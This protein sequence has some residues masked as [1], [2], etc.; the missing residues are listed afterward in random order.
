MSNAELKESYPKMQTDDHN[1][2][3]KLFLTVGWVT[4]WWIVIYFGIVILFAFLY[5]RYATP[6]FE[7]Q[8]DVQY[9]DRSKDNSIDLG[10]LVSSP[11]ADRLNEEMTLLNSKG[12]KMR[13][14]RSLPLQASYYLTEHVKS[15]EIY[16]ASPFKVDVEIIDSAIIGSKIDFEIIDQTNY[17]IHYN[18]QGE[19]ISFKYNFDKDYNTP[20]FN[21]KATLNSSDP[22][23]VNNKYYFVIND[24]EVI[25]EKIE[26]EI[27]VEVDNLYGG[28]ITIYY[29]DKN[30][31]K[32]KDVV[33]T[34]AKEIVNLSL[35]RKANGAKT[36]I[37]FIQG[38]IDSLEKELFNQETLLKDFKKE[39]LII[40]PE[41]AENNVV[42]KLNTIDQ[43]K[44][45][46][47][48]EE[49]SL[50]WLKDF[51]ENKNNDIAAL[52][53]Y[54]GDFKFNDF[55]PYLNSLLSLEKEKENIG[56]SVPKTD[57]RLASINKQI[58]QVKINFK[59][60][61]KNAEEKLNVRKKYLTEEQK[62]YETEFLGLPEIQSEFARLT[63]LN[64]L[65][66]KYYLLLLEK[67][68]EYEI[69]LAG[70]SSDYVILDAGKQG[71]L[72]SPVSTKVWGIC[73]LIGI[74]VSFAHVYLKFISH[75]TIIGVPDVESATQVPLLGVLPL[76]TTSKTELAQIVV[77]KNPKSHIAEA[78]RTIRSNIQYFLRNDKTT[79]Q[80]I[81]ITSTISGEGKTFIA[82]NLANVIAATGKKVVL[83]DFDLRKPKIHKAIEI[84]NDRGVSN[85]LI[86][87]FTPEECIKYS[88]EC[89]CDILIAGPVPPN[90]A[91]LL[92]GHETELLLEYLQLHYDY[93]I[94]DCPP[95]GI[96]SDSLP[97]MSRVDLSIY[98]LRANYSKLTFIENINRL[99]HN[100]RLTNLCMIVNDANASGTDYGY[101]YGYGY[102]ESEYHDYYSDTGFFLPLW[103]K[104]FKTN[105]KNPN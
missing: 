33:N 95:V 75:N 25:T 23:N 37:T 93:I 52:A 35:E 62:K 45:D 61:I 92:I 28:K 72:V 63:R 100:N 53:N 58:D 2:D 44:F 12:Y 7:S 30:S 65:K 79:G 59:D 67:Q 82:L 6:V 78:F 22:I 55:S 4:R 46:V 60:A 86:K 17:N 15:G 91:E 71:K 38:Q 19:T 47:L 39:N 18:Y 31:I 24:L 74:G 9:K 85:I 105:K 56:L 69:T 34:I 51:T 101:G 16:K 97:L 43:S 77:T 10:I 29:R 27:N 73:L 50:Q 21:I 36:I 20:A 3:W 57:P 14:L 90:P 11:N 88:P 66:E 5:L 68:S 84:K 83:V 42:Q 70:M 1:F 13:A 99:Y 94:I 87:Q 64:D 76:F 81:S 96:V 98:I 26:K 102:G 49:K 32:S 80:L 54:F 8:T 48:L 104:F 103:R 89:G 40:S 41:L